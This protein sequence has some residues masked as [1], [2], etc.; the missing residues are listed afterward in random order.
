VSGSREEKERA[1][2]SRSRS[3]SPLFPQASV[4]RNQAFY[5]KQTCYT[6]AP[7]SSAQ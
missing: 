4:I 6:I 1:E 5:E 7:H 2:Q 3:V